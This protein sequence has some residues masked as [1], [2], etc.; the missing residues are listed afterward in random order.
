LELVLE[1]QEGHVQDITNYIETELKIGKT[2]IAQQIRAEL[3]EKA[4]G[5]F[6]WVVL[7]VGILNIELDRGQ[8]STLRR[9]L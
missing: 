9:K 6:M 8:V 2:K 1:R 5:I 3:Q 4:L 7:V